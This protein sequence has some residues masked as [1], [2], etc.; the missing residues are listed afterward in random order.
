MVGALD[1][2]KFDLKKNCYGQNVSFPNIYDLWHIHWWMS[3]FPAVFFVSCDVLMCV[4]FSVVIGK[5]LIFDGAEHVWKV[6]CFNVSVTVFYF[7]VFLL[8]SKDIKLN[9]QQRQRT[10]NAALCSW[11]K[12]HLNQCV[13]LNTVLCIFMANTFVQKFGSYFLHFFKNNL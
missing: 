10:V 2:W 13:W 5:N 7:H 8:H 6:Q 3:S 12:R 9:H 4:N 11:V 1:L